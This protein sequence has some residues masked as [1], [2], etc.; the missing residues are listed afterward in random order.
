MGLQQ[1]ALAP[2]PSVLCCCTPAVAECNPASPPDLQGK[3]HWEGHM[4]LQQMDYIKFHRLY[5][6]TARPSR[7][8]SP[9][10]ERDCTLPVTGA[11]PMPNLCSND[12]ATLQSKA[13]LTQHTAL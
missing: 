12:N 7:F 11:D 4:H 8:C 10:R 5:N 2:A 1:I 6:T 3:A 13:W 9:K